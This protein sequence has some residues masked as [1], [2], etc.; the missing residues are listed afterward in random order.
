MT[1]ALKSLAAFEDSDASD[2]FTEIKRCG[3]VKGN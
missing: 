3:E 2:A 1:I